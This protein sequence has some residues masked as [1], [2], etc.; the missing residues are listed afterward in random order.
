MNEWSGLPEDDE[1]AA[2]MCI[3]PPVPPLPRTPR[4]AMT[5][6]GARR[7]TRGWHDLH[8]VVGRAGGQGCCPGPSAIYPSAHAGGGGGV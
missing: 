8:V 7:G 5:G 2:A 1:P 3:Q 4:H 6:R